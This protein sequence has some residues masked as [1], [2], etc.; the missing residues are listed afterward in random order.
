MSVGSLR[1]ELTPEMLFL[2]LGNTK[3]WRFCFTEHAWKDV[4]LVYTPM[5]VVK[6]VVC[7]TLAVYPL[8]GLVCFENLL[9]CFVPQWAV[10][11]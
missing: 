4:G 7:S 9:V 10:V 8:P 1:Q 6:K 11:N 3:L 5:K 2:G